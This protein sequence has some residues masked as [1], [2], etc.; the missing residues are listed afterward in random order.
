MT[1]P[2]QKLFGSPARLKLLRLF[3]FNPRQQ[4]S[5]AEAARHAQVTPAAARSEMGVFANLGLLKR[6]PR[7]SAARYGLNP[8]FTYTAALQGLLLNAPMRSVELYRRLRSTGTIKLIIVAGIFMGEWEGR[9]DLLIVGDRVSDKKLR[10]KIRALESEL[11]KELK[12]ALLTT[13]DFYYRLN[14]SD[15][16]VRDVLDY[17]HA[18]AFDR[19][20]IGLK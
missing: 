16:L 11:G 17:N 8:E 6:G 10:T 13:Q 3:L 5:V 4:F 15:K 2:L 1:D 14:M 7:R 19:L 20:N 12:Y 18:V 9:L